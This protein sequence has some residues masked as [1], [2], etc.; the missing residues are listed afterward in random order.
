MGNSSYQLTLEYFVAKMVDPGEDFPVDMK[1]VLKIDEFREIFTKVSKV[2][3][4][5]L[6]SS[7]FSG[8]HNSMAIDILEKMLSQISRFISDEPVLQ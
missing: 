6:I 5:S 2:T 1:P 3:A 7:N 4:E 8:E